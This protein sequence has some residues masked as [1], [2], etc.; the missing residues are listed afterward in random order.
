MPSESPDSP[1]NP[2]TNEEWNLRPPDTDA[3]PENFA[4]MPPSYGGINFDYRGQ[5]THG[6]VPLTPME[7]MDDPYSEGAIVPIDVLP[8]TPQ[9][10]PVPVVIISEDPAHI[11]DWRAGQAYA[12]GSPTQIVNK[13]NGRTTVQ[14]QN[15]SAT[16]AVYIGPDAM[17]NAT[18]GW[19]IPPNGSFT[20]AAES[21]IWAVSA[22]GNP[23]PMCWYTEFEI[24]LP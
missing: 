3:M 9:A 13:Q 10:D 23:V 14:I 6:V 12:A 16:V 15:L 11:K 8:S 1:P 22:D 18:T 21:A 7:R 19:R 2:Y 17:T 20:M 4:P 5:Q 24:P